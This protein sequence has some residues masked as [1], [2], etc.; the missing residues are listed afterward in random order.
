MRKIVV[1]AAVAVLATGLGL[2][3]AEKAEPKNGDVA[4]VVKGN[5]EFAF[6]L[7][8]QLREKEGNRFFSPYSISTALAMT[9]VGARGDTATEMAK[10]L[11]FTLPPDKLNPAFAELIKQ[12]NGEGRK[13][14]YQLSVANALWGQSDLGF[15][16]DF[17]KLTRDNYGAGLNEVNFAG[18]T[19][20]ARKQINAWVEKQTH[21]KIKELFKPD[22]LNPGT[23]LVLT[24]AIYFKGD[25]NS[26]F[27]K[28]LT[29]DESFDVGDG[30]I[31]AP[32]MHQTAQLKYLDAGT[33]QVLEM[34]YAGKEL[35]MVVLLPKKVAGLGDLEKSL[36]AEKLAGWL[37]KVR[38]AA[39][40]VSLPKFKTTSEFE[41]KDQLSALGMKKAFGPGADFSGIS[42]T[43]LQITA[44]VHK[45]FID[46]NEEG[47]E[48]AAATGVAVG[49]KGGPP[50]LQEFRAD[51]PFL[52]LIRDTRTDN[53][54][55]L[56]RIVNPTK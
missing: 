28:D 9:H 52:F 5:N 10:A 7:Y 45:A 12:V 30:K 26:P 48:A 53:V 13:R 1:I 2:P 41:L 39:I 21:D 16:E 31:K 24:N 36:T 37:G 25:W 29:R 56:G 38:E 46:V 6:D 4:A 51:H 47:T 40:I 11:H 55:F 33:L 44:V 15:K 19:E 20:A 22:I 34:P 18:A 32:M 42:S 8:G 35:S 50:S 43:E 23:R 17:L 3:A 27:K 49:D 54:L 14:G